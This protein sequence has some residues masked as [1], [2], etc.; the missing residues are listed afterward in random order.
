MNVWPNLMGDD[1]CQKC[2]IFTIHWQCG[3]KFN[4]PSKAIWR[5]ALYRCGTP[6]MWREKGVLQMIG[7]AAGL[8]VRVKE[9]SREMGIRVTEEYERREITKKKMD[10]L[11][12]A[13]ENEKAQNIL[14]T[15]GCLTAMQVVRKCCV[16][17]GGHTSICTSRKS[18]GEVVYL[19]NL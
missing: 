9:M 5:N 2:R 15:T 3:F 12:L 7:I 17:I 16:W 10:F 14:K 18:W 1:V 8:S 6:A 13:W 19:V 4:Q 11:Q